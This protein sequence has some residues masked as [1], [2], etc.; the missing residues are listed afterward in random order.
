MTIPVASTSTTAGLL[1]NSDFDKFNAK[2][3]VIQE[4][5][6]ETGVNSFPT[7]VVTGTGS[8]ATIAYTLS[9]TPSSRSKVK[10]YIN[11][12]RISNAAYTLSGS[13]ITY[14]ASSNNNYVIT[15]TDRVQ[16]D[17]FY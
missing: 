9:K 4:V 1:N 13:K 10:M 14:T 7:G 15:S 3:D 17:Y 5:S 6:D 2:Q 16:F 11:G 12:I 8:N